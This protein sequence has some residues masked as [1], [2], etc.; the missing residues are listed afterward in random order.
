MEAAKQIESLPERLRAL[1]ASKDRAGQFL[2]ALFSDLFLYS[3]YMIP[4]IS[5]R[6]VEID[7]AMR[8]GYANK[9]GPF[10]L[11]DALGF[12][13]VVAR[14]ENEKRSIPANVIGAIEAGAASLYGFSSD[15]GRPQTEYFDFRT[16]GYQKIEE[17]AGVVRLIDIKSARGVVKKNAGASLV[18][19]GDGV[20]CVE[21]HSKMNALG[22]DIIAMLYAGIEE[23]SKNYQAMVI[24]NQGD[25]FSVGANL[26]MVLL[27]AQEGEW[28]DLNEAIYRFQQVNMALKYAEKPV[29]AA[30]FG[31]AL[32]GGCEI[33][34]HATRVQA[35][36]ELY[37]GL[38]EVGV[39]LIPG[40]G[41]CKELLAR[42][43]DARKVFE[44]IGYAK[45]S[46]SAEDARKLGLLNKTDA[47][48]MNPERLIGDAKALALSLAP[49]YAPGVPRNDIKVSGESGFAMMKVGLWSARQGGY[50]SDYDVVVG[51]KLAH[52]LSGGKLTGEPLVSENYLLDL[53]REAFLSLCGNTKTRERMAHTLKTGKPLRN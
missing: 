2:W 39:G 11:W 53:E 1:V 37:M 50:I 40:G 18:D 48:S 35:S 51:E 9:L 8:W 43:R 13:D 12:R 5:D 27:A 34:L 42:L 7:Q 28:D 16:H 25:H 26:M 3:S 36:A 46:G 44:L 23:T 19:L 10:E 49:G 24:A 41:G 21:F 17:R 22:E 38:V 4:E 52:I 33:A 47:V 29:V 31:Q 30:P 32:G 20:L 15:G 45:V 14:M 6:I